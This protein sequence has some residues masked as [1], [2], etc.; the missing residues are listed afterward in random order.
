MYPVLAQDN[1]LRRALVLAAVLAGMAL[2]APTRAWATTTVTRPL[3]EFTSFACPVF[4]EENGE[5]VTGTGQCVI[6]TTVTSTPGGGYQSHGEFQCHGTAVGQTTGTNFIFNQAGTFAFGTNGTTVTS[7]QV[8][9]FELISRGSAPNQRV[10]VTMHIT[11][12]SNGN[13]AVFFD[14]F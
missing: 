5:V 12:D 10:Q 13:V 6:I 8:S 3:M 7:T 9:N 14:D 2:V 11:I 4:P 1:P